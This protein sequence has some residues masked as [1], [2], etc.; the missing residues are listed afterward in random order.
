MDKKTE[1]KW[2][3]RQFKLRSTIFLRKN[4]LYVMVIG[5]LAVLGVAAALIFTG[6][7][8]EG[9]PVNRSDDERLADAAATVSP[10]PAP[11]AGIIFPPRTAAPV[12]TPIP[13]LPTAA[14]GG[15]PTLPPDFTFT[16]EDTPDPMQSMLQPP[17][18]GSVIRVFAVNSL[19]WNETLQQWMTH[20][21]VDVTANK[22]DPV[23]AVLEGTVESVRT[24][25]M[26]GV[27]VVIAHSNGMKSVYANL[28]ETPPVAAGDAVASRQVI[29]YIGDTALGE[30]AERSHLHFEIT[31]NGEAI[32][33]EGMITFNKN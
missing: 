11:T 9:E 14:P 24:D 2:R 7:S 25:D 28:K 1:R 32:D 6:G 20:P 27:T 19:I 22:G 4:G 16:P 13:Y 3:M 15:E 21:G 5:C 29:G 12:D 10:S 18:D 8:K 33:P 30:C 23:Y 17:V 31:V 26:L